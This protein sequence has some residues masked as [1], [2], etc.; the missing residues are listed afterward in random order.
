MQE[1][2]ERISRRGLLKITLPRRRGLLQDGVRLLVLGRR[3][4]CPLLPRTMYTTTAQVAPLWIDTC[5]LP[6]CPVRG[7][8]HSRAAYRWPEQAPPSRGH[9]HGI[10]TCEV[11]CGLPHPAAYRRFLLPKHSTR[12]WSHSH[13]SQPARDMHC[14]ETPQQTCPE[15]LPKSGRSH[16]RCLS[17]LEDRLQ[18]EN[19]K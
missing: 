3:G 14:D 7:Q 5:S 12:L 19:Y 9:M 1:L 6:S 11:T 4:G 15:P 17:L 16:L 13:H 18:Y 10:C 8:H 2:W